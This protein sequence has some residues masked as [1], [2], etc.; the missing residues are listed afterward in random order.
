MR[1]IRVNTGINF[2]WTLRLGENEVDWAYYDLTLEMTKPSH[3]KEI[4]DF[5]IEGSVLKFPYKPNQCG[6]YII[7]AYLNRYKPTEA[8]LDNKVFEAV[9]WSWNTSDE[10]DDLVSETL[11]LEGN[12]QVAGNSASVDLSEYYTKEE[13][14]TKFETTLSVED[15]ET[16]NFASESWVT[17]NYQPKGDYQPAGNYL[18]SIPS[19]YITEDELTNRGYITGGDLDKYVTEDE[20]ETRLEGLEGGSGNV[21]LTGYA[22]EQWVEDKGYITESEI[23]GKGFITSIPAQYVTESELANK[24]YITESEIDGKGFITSIPAQYVTESELAKKNYV[25]QDD[26]TFG[27]FNL[28]GY[29]TKFEADELFVQKGEVNM[30]DYAT[31]YQLAMKQDKLVSGTNIKTV[32]GES[33]IGEG[34]I[35]FDEFANKQEALVS[36]VNIKTINGQS[37]LGEGDIMITGGDAPDMTGYVTTVELNNK[38]FITSIPDEYITE[39]ELNERNYATVDSVEAKQDVLVVGQ[40]IKTINGKSILGAGNIQINANAEVD[41]S[42][43]YTKSEVDEIVSNID[44]GGEAPDLTGYATESWVTANYQPKGDYQPAGNYLTSIPDE[45]ITESELNKAISNIQIPSVD[46]TGYATE[47]WVENKGYLTNIPEEYVTSSELET[48]L[49]GIN[50]EV[51]DEVPTLTI[52]F[53]TGEYNDRFLVETIFQRLLNNKPCNIVLL[54]DEANGEE[55]PTYSMTDVNSYQFQ[56]DNTVCV[57]SFDVVGKSWYNVTMFREASLE[58]PSAEYYKVAQISVNTDTCYTEVNNL[59]AT[60]AKK[61]TGDGISTIKKMTQ[62]EYD[63]ITPDTNTLYIIVE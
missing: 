12:M 8:V 33:I 13:I 30:D 61:V 49:E 21:D 63:A 7:S 19:E 51:A 44:T 37:I 5:T 27:D 42:G 47:N 55:I 54:R 2:L 1:K 3:A 46:L 17:A 36:G 20:L 24:G 35:S 26:L 31:I 40:N 22:T 29:Y 15:L 43:Y 16:Y 56:L 10:S 6:Q 4:I 59:K 48:R 34:N 57:L 50:V 38:G 53:E 18:T 25:T 11:S 58:T 41:L 14:D 45:Y 9:R 62:A 52:D 60:V 32:N 28:D 39:E 23:D